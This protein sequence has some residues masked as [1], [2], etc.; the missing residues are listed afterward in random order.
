MALTCEVRHS[1]ELLFP[2][3]GHLDGLVLLHHT[4]SRHALL[5]GVVHYLVEVVGL[6]GV[7]DVEE[8]VSRWSLALS[9]LVR[10]VAH[11]ECI[12]FHQ[13]VDV[14]D[15]QLL[16]LGHLD[17]PDLVLLVEVLLPLDHLLQPIFVADAL[18]RQVKLLTTRRSDMN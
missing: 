14:L 16:V 3:L 15:T 6:L 7:Q 11:E 9:I 13:R 4:I 17:V 12:L 2:V 5:G 18:V 10:E 8:V 1:F